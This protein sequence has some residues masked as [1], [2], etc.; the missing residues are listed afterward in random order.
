MKGKTVEIIIGGHRSR[1]EENDRGQWRLLD[2]E[3]Y[4]ELEELL[5]GIPI[6]DEELRWRDPEEILQEIALH[7]RQALRRQ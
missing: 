5:E 7:I 2:L 1:I 3:E 4:P 6:P